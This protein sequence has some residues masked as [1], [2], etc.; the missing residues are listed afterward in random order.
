MLYN[1]RCPIT[2][3]RMHTLLGQ[4]RA[5]PRI[6]W[7]GAR[8]RPAERNRCELQRRRKATLRRERWRVR[9][10]RQGEGRAHPTRRRRRGLAGAARPPRDR[11]ICP[12]KAS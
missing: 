1:F 9:V 3:K 4:V 8:S 7:E 11:M 12:E 6:Q 2:D 10:L 5:A